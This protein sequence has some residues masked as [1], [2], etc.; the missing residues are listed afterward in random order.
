MMKLRYLLLTFGF[1]LL[2]ISAARAATGFWTGVTGS[3]A[4]WTDPANWN[5]GLMPD[6]PGDSAAIQSDITGAYTI[7]LASG[8]AGS[9]TLG[10][11]TIGD[12]NASYFGYTIAAGVTGS[13]LIFNNNGSGATLGFPATG[14]AANTISAGISLNDNL[15]ID[16]ATPNTSEHVLSG[17]I[18]NGSGTYGLT[19]NGATCLIQLSGANTFKGGVTINGGRVKA[20]SS[21][22]AFG[23]GLVTINSGGQAYLSGLS[24]S[25]SNNFNIAGVGYDDGGATAYSGAIRLESATVNLVGSITLASNARIGAYGGP[26]DGTVSGPISGSFE[27]EVAAMH[28]SSSSSI[29]MSSAANSTTSTRLTSM[30]GT[31]NLALGNANA[32]STGPLTLSSNVV[33]KLSGFNASFASLANVGTSATIGNYGG[34]SDSTLTV[35]GAGASFAYDGILIN[36]NA[37][38]LNLVKLGSGTMTLLGPGARH[39]GT[40]TINNGVLSLSNCVN[41]ASAVTA[42]APGTLDLNAEAGGSWV[43]GKTLGGNGTL[44]KS[45][46]DTVTLAAAN[47]CIG[48]TVIR[49]GTLA[50]GASG[51]LA[52]AFITNNATFDVSAA[53]GGYHLASGQTLCG[54]GS[55]TGPITVDNGATLSPGNSIGTLTINGNLILAGKLFIEVD[56]T[57]APTCDNVVVTGNVTNTGTGTVTITNLNPSHPFIAGD[58]LALFNQAVANGHLMTIAGTPGP[59]LAWTNKLEVDGTVGVLVSTGP[60]LGSVSP[61]PVVG[62]SFPVT[63]TLT[64]SGFVGPCN[65]LLTNLATSVASSNPVASTDGTHLS[66]PAVLGAAA[67]NATWNATVVNNGG[68][69]SGQVTFT[70]NA[71]PRPRVLAVTAL[72]ATNLVMSGSGGSGMAGYPYVVLGT[73]NV[74]QSLGLWQRLATNYY[75]GT[76]SFSCTNAIIPGQPRFFFILE[77]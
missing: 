75:N 1:T 47:T 11:L 10:A 33:L 49:S 31:L 2:S 5:G 72:G 7:N 68:A 52:S 70:V 16:G 61:N 9:R 46:A 25:L 63:L 24:G 13:Q 48:P 4:A 18:T 53:A 54:T 74:G 50:L 26:T 67:A 66:V 59:G 38:V 21:V 39:T 43:F 44:T 12:T 17:I 3:P 55:V 60:T 34:G 77:Q 6:G 42:N 64:G 76:G 27:L 19:K 37:H 8:S 22:K 73:T 69:T 23:T 65:V 40:T 32:L 57:A 62:S 58:S 30:G 51:S 20:A 45:G 71:P 56:K 14:G 29:N 28:S 15:T 41:W 35:G 36:G